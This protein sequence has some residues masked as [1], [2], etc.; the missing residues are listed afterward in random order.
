M[1]FRINIPQLEKLAKNFYDITQTLVTIYD[2]NQEKICAYPES[3]CGFCAEIRKN[4]IL[5]EKCRACDQMAFSMCKK[6]RQTYIYQCHM[7]LVEVATPILCN[8]LIIGYML[9]GQIAPDKNKNGLIAFAENI[10]VQYQLD[11]DTIKAE[12]P[13]IK[14]RTTEYITAISN[15]LEMCANHIWLNSIISV[16]NEG[17]AYSIDYF[18]Q[19]NL[20]KDLQIKYL[21]EVF[22]ISRGTLYNISKKNFGCGVTEYVA[23]CRLSA[24]KKLLKKPDMSISEIAE[25]VGF[26]DTNYFI[27]FFKKH[28]GFTPKKYRNMINSQYNC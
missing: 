4:P 13:A 28:T 3:L 6:T 15:L 18:I 23:L 21:C 19:Q 9:F 10:A 11:N 26:S 2:E 22:N 12:I 8:N 24:A 14:Y 5:A 7:G 20:N 16:H 1:L 27:R 17:L 25:S